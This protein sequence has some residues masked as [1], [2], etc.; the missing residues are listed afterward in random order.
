VAPLVPFKP[1]K[2]VPF[3]PVLTLLGTIFAVK[4]LELRSGLHEQTPL[5]LDYLN[6]HWQESNRWLF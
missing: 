1:E 6:I 5:V 2:R 3:S 4:P